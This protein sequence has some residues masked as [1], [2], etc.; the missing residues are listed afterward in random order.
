MILL[1]SDAELVTQPAIGGSI[2]SW[3]VGGHDIMRSSV[4]ADVRDSACYPLFP[5]SNRVAG[6]AFTFAGQRYELP[7][8]LNDWAIH[9]AGWQSPWRETKA[10]H[11]TLD[12]P[13]GRLWPFPFLAEQEFELAPRELACTLRLTNM[14]TEPA[15]AAF[16]LHPFFPRNP[17]TTLRFRAE[18]VWMSDAHLIPTHRAPV[19]P[20]WDFAQER[21]I[22]ATAFD[23]CFSGWTGSAR[24]A[25]PDK[26]LCVT[27]RAPGMRHLV[28]Y[29]PPGR[30]FLAVEPVQNVTD[31]LNRMETEPD[32]GMTIL[33]PGETMAARMTFT[34]EA[35]Q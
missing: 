30:D 3:R 11:L 16:G 23:N 32:H 34:V 18:S 29:I 13:G 19:P 1:A 21:P 12:H 10:G 4:S 8:L 28:V 22:G 26:G 24:I 2:T 5:F 31:A 15:P 6:R 14:H 7:A 33:A 9:G 17:D 35:L 20:E 25:W 27:I